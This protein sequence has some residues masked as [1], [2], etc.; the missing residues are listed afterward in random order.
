MKISM[1]IPIYNESGTIGA[2][3]EQLD[4]LPGD[5]EILFAD[6]GSRDDTI[7]KIGSRYTVLR[8]PK[9][10]A[11]QM[12][13]AA[14]QA[15]A[16]VLWFVHCDSVLPQDA[17]GQISAA[18]GQ[19]AKWG[20]FHIG[21]DYHGPFM[22]CNTYFSN[23]RA[24][25]GIAFGDQGI[26]VRRELFQEMGGFPDL[27]IMEDYEFSRRMKT[28]KIPITQLPGRIITSGRRYRGSFPLLTMW[29]MF[30]LRCLYRRGVD[31]QEIARR[32]RDIR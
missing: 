5:W 15:T 12:N 13:F 27:P 29:K 4:A 26:W 31:I 11:N 18:V 30:W 28:A 20:C 32:Y 17:H 24:K 6:G 19:G 25:K 7:D 10:R 2:M 22:G 8:C 14:A 16:D 3:L 1:I 9:G 23:R 21:F